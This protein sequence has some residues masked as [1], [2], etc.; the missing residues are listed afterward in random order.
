MRRLL[1]I[2]LLLV[3]ALGASADAK[4]RP[5]VTCHSGAAIITQGTLRVFG[6]P[7][8]SPAEGVFRGDD[9][10]AC[11]PGGRPRGIGQVGADEGTDSETIDALVF[12]GSRYLAEQSTDDGEGG[13]TVTVGATDLRNGRSGAFANGVGGVDE[14]PPLRVLSDGRLLTS[15]DGVRLVS[16]N[17][18]SG[19]GKPISDSG[20]A[21]EVAARGATAY[22]TEHPGAAQRGSARRRSR[23]APARPRTPRSARSTGYPTSTPVASGAPARRSPARSWSACSPAAPRSARAATTA[24]E[25]S[26]SRP[27]PVPRTSGSSTTAGCSCCS[28]TRP[29]PRP[30]TT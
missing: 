27:S 11:L 1:A 2:A 12:D 13:P 30:S 8:R 22:W 5:R 6:I 3:V 28:A 21:D 17:A 20:D 24:A 4:K 15:D 29:A 9:V 18:K 16:A 7:F 14:V 19:S 10:Y 26:A 25:S 23:L